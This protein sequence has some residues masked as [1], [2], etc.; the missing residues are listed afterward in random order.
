VIYERIFL[1][2]S[3]VTSLVGVKL[4]GNAHFI[5]IYSVKL[6]CCSI[7]RG[8]LSLAA[9]SKISSEENSLSVREISH[10]FDKKQSDF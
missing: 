6:F 4:E 9:S 5:T 3:N 7:Q 1:V 10:A 2:L 8:S